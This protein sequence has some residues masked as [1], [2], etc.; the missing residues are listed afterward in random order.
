MKITIDISQAKEFLK[1][2]TYAGCLDKAAEI[3]KHLYN[4]ED[5]RQVLGWVHTDTA[6]VQLEEIL[7]K[8]VEV[9]QEGDVLVVVG[10]GGSNQAARA[11]VTALQNP[12]D[13]LEIVYMGNSLSPYDIISQL[14]RLE[15]KSIYINVIA[16][17]FETL[18]PGSHFRILRQMLS[19]RYDKAELARRVIL[20]G[21]CGSRLQEIAVENG[22]TFF[23]FPKTIGGRYSGFSPPGLFPIAVAG[24]DVEGF[25]NG[26]RQ[27]E[28][29]CQQDPRG[30]PAAVYA[31]TRSLLYRKGFNIEMM[32]SFEPRLAYFNKWWIQLFGE[33]EGKDGKGIFPSGAVYSEDLHSM[34]QYM[35]EGRRC[36]LETFLDVKNPG[37][38]VVIQ[39][40]PEF[41]DGFDYLD[42]KD[43]SQMNKIAAKAA[44]E[45]HKTGGVPCLRFVLEDISAETFGE[46][47]Y[48]FMMAC[49]VSGILLKVNPFD[50]DGVEAYKKRMLEALGKVTS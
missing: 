8:A 30:N 19:S 26:V 33:S 27:A 21:T 22:Y 48:Y 29:R 17:N 18:E 45:A 5:F 44:I 47:L 16:K 12:E 37:A 41:R 25:L 36:L 32:V 3:Q 31:V 10:V 24:L 23:S 15:G 42:G 49:G 14:K 46:L 35:Q 34:G 43:F 50:Q 28:Y 6:A 2:E 11:M 4:S 38:S 7:K 40:D 13:R 20:T 9:R 1:Q 39:A